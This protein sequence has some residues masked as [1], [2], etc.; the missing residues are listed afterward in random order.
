MWARILR[1]AELR[2]WKLHTLRH[3]FASLLIARGEAPTYVQKQLGHHSAAFTL[4]VYGHF[5][6]RA[7]HRGVDGLDDATGRNLYAT[8]EERAAVIR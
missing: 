7:D 2:Y 8:K 5:V 4:T 6:P 1:R 3:T